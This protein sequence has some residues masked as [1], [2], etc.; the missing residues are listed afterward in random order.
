[1]NIKHPIGQGPLPLSLPL[2]LPPSL[3]PSL[4]LADTGFPSHAKISQAFPSL[5]SDK[6]LGSGEGLGTRQLC[7]QVGG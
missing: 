3:S 1:M 5:L 6:K 2:S 4:S 7:V